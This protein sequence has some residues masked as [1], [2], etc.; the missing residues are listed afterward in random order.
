MIPRAVLP[1]TTYIVS[2]LERRKDRMDSWVLVHIFRNVQ[3]RTDKAF[4]MKLMGILKVKSGQVWG[5]SQP[6]SFQGSESNSFDM[7]FQDD[8]DCGM[9][10][11]QECKKE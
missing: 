11:H 10:L 3:A 7:N 9:P 2:L 4:V 1:F 5:K 6:V 8:K